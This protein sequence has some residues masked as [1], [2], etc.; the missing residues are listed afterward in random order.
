[1]TTAK[2]SSPPT[3]AAQDTT[4]IEQQIARA[5]LAVEKNK[6]ASDTLH[7][8]WRL[9]LQRLSYL[10]IIISMHQA[11]SIFGACLKDCRTYNDIFEAMAAKISDPGLTILESLQYS[12][13]ESA[14]FLVGLVMSVSLTLF[15]LRNDTDNFKAPSFSLAT[16]CI[17]IILSLH[18]NPQLSHGCLDEE[19]RAVDLEPSYRARGFPVVL[20][21]YLIVSVCYWFMGVQAR[22][23]DK[24]V[25]L[26][27]NLDKDLA[28]SKQSGKKNKS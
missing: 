21:F 22:L 8:Q 24:N 4:E 2:A 14:E 7:S 1:M 19:L 26:I 17:P 27:D 15:L 13:R 28:T 16:T 23:H 10:L 9:H 3:Q 25:V 6:A 20:V 12:L 5:R 18:F 11:Q